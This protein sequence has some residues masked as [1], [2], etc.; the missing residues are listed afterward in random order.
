MAYIG[1][2]RCGNQSIDNSV[3]IEFPQQEIVINVN[4]IGSGITNNI[5]QIR[6]VRGIL[7]DVVLRFN[8]ITDRFEIGFVGETFYN[9]VINKTEVINR[10]TQVTHSRHYFVD[11]RDIDSC[12]LLLPSFANIGDSFKVTDMYKQFD[13]KNIIIRRYNN[14]IPIPSVPPVS[15][16]P[17]NLQ[18]IMGHEDDLILERCGITYEFIYVDEEYGWHLC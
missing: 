13:K 7:P 16:L 14:M 11:A 18:K 3:S 2:I 5:S 8:D 6:I 17:T 1:L 4:E 10:S 15:V 12:D 9:V